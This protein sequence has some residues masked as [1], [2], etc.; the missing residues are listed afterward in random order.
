MII[1]EITIR[2]HKRTV[3]GQLYLPNT[4]KFP[5]LILSHGFNGCG[6]DFSEYADILS[7]NG[8]GAFIFDFCGGSIRSKSELS[9]TEMTVFTEKEDLTAVIDFIKKLNYTGEIF[10][11][12]ASMGGLVSALTAEELGHLISGIILLYPAF[13]VA[14][15]WN[16]KFPRIDDIPDVYRVWEMPL[17]KCFFETLHRFSVF[18]HIGN[19]H[20]NVLILHG[21]EDEIVPLEYSHRAN[22]IYT[23]SKLQVFQNEAHGFSDIATEE[24][25]NIILDFICKQ[26]RIQNQ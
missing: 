19:Y 18:E 26:S 7:Q 13:C 17:G 22:E 21:D 9:T 14:D 25:I 5:V 10:L 23:N 3:H 8:I 12:G 20:G 2:H 15:N 24:T 11:F 16:E 6:N 1:E 4:D